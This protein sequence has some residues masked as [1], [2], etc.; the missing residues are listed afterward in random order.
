MRDVAV[1]TRVYS[2]LSLN[3]WLIADERPI[4]V[5]LRY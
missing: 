4:D 5:R 1:G 3:L 2:P